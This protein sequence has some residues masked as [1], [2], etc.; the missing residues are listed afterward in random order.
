MIGRMNSHDLKKWQLVKMQDDLTP[1]QRY[2]NKMVRRMEKSGFPGNDR[3]YLMTLEA[4]AA[5][6]KLMME[7]HYLGCEPGTVGTPRKEDPP[8]TS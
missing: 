6:Q 4:Q 7:M 5:M 2:L 3:L 1:A 8:A